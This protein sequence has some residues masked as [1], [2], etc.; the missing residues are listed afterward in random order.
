MNASTVFY[1]LQMVDQDGK[2][3]YSKTIAVLLKAANSQL[4]I[5]P[6]PVKGTLYLQLSSA[7]NEKIS[8]QIIDMKGSVLQQQEV[9]VSVGNMSLSFNAS[10]LAKGNYVLLIKGDNLM[11]QREFIKD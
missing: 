4:T 1:R 2:F 9:R 6:N 7:K 8:I 3:T 10:K 11:Q 5:F